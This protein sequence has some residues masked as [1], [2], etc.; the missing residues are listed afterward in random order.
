M[1]EAQKAREA[2]LLAEQ[3]EKEEAA[4]KAKQ[5]ADRKAA[6]EARRKAEQDRRA[7]ET[8]DR[9]LADA[10][11][12][13]E[14]LAAALKKAEE[15]DGKLR[16]ELKKKEEEEAARRQK[17][18]DE[19][20]R[21]SILKSIDK[22]VEKE[23]ETLGCTD[24]NVELS[25]GR[26][27][28]LKPLMFEKNKTNLEPYS[29][30]ILHQLGKTLNALEMVAKRRGLPMAR[31]MVEGHTNCADEKKRLNDYHVKLSNDRAHKIVKHLK[32]YNT[33]H[34][35]T[36][37]P[38]GFGGARRIYHEDHEDPRMRDVT[39]NQRVEFNLLNANELTDGL[40]H[41]SHQ[42][43]VKECSK[44]KPVGKLHVDTGK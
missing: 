2:K 41:V 32:K 14:G 10:K 20:R 27:E 1:L 17:E 8:L 35:K 44:R 42:E 39:L 23:L 15:E 21:L 38:K 43:L 34:P 5:V 31:F 4:R 9:K 29:V 7:K 40:H 18:A 19:K 16:A 6:E 28:I 26:V 3:K 25:K 12:Q 33:C 37:T 22:D 30:K 13:A 24:V 36:L 11:L